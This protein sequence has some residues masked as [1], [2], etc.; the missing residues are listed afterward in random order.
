MD[1]VH[2]CTCSFAWFSGVQLLLH[3]LTNGLFFFLVQTQQTICKDMFLW[4]HVVML[5]CE[6]HLPIFCLDSRR[7]SCVCVDEWQVSTI[8]NFLMFVLHVR[9]RCCFNLAN[10]LSCTMFFLFHRVLFQAPW[11]ILLIQSMLHTQMHTCKC[12][13]DSRALGIGYPGLLASHFS[14]VEPTMSCQVP[15][16]LEPPPTHTH[17]HMQR[18]WLETLCWL[19]RYSPSSYTVPLHPLHLDKAQATPSSPD[20]ACIC[21]LSSS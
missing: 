19:H 2:T 9:I 1:N 6:F 3:V 16:P 4:V 7:A 20:I 21:Q 5:S 12:S 10:S 17:T 15:L 11:F 13:C 14:L 8:E 18:L